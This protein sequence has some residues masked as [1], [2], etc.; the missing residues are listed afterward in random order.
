M[1]AANTTTTINN[2]VKRNYRKQPVVIKAFINTDQ[3]KAIMKAFKNVPKEANKYNKKV[4]KQAKVDERKEAKE[5]RESEKKAIRSNAKA[6]VSD[7]NMEKKEVL[8][9]HIYSD[10]FAALNN[11]AKFS[12]PKMALLIEALDKKT[13][14][15]ELTKAYLAMNKDN[16]E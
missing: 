14:Q 10:I 12:K 11:I 7:M 8:L 15:S 1:S 6:A 16:K 9:R 3:K 4:E 2:K 5:L 13:T